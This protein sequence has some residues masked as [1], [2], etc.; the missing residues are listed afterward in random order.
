MLAEVWRTV[1]VGSFTGW[2]ACWGRFPP[3]HT[4]YSVKLL[5]C[6]HRGRVVGY[7]PENSHIL[8]GNHL[9]GKGEAGIQSGGQARSWGGSAALPQAPTERA[10][11]QVSQ[12]LWVSREPLLPAGV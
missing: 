6:W 2:G 11:C 4:G 9:A 1:V 10:L 3:S 5:M 7:N 8:G 12:P